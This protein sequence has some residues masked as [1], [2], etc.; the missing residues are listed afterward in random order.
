[1]ESLP[2]NQVFLRVQAAELSR[3]SFQPEILN[4]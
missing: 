4:P 2:P 3:P 1:V